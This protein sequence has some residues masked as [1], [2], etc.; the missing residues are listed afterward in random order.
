MLCVG[1]SSPDGAFSE[2][3]PF[4]KAHYRGRVLHGERNQEGPMRETGARRVT[5]RSPANNFK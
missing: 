5:R 3:L 1:H 4:R 2:Q